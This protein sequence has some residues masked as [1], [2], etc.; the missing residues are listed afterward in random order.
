[1]LRCK[2]KLGRSLALINGFIAKKFFRGKQFFF[3][4]ISVDFRKLCQNCSLVFGFF[5]HLTHV[6]P[7]I[8]EEIVLTEENSTFF[9][10]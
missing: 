7:P 2:V 9:K 3:I 4:T 10:K 8:M 1:M 6:G 5:V